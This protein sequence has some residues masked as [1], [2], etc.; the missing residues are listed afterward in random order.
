MIGVR[1]FAEINGFERNAFRIV[2]FE[3]IGEVAVKDI[4]EDGLGLL[5]IVRVEWETFDHES[6]CK[7]E[8][9]YFVEHFERLHSLP[10]GN[11]SLFFSDEVELF[12]SSGED[13]GVDFFGQI[14][15]V[16]W[17]LEVQFFVY[18]L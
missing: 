3:V 1:L 9:R 2:F 6:V 4:G 15:A 8:D 12:Y 10:T 5:G 14:V 16:V 18:R 11:N 13:L 17:W 7:E